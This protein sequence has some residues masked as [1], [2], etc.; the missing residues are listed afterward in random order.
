MTG[1]AVSFFLYCFCFLLGSVPFGLLIA[2]VFSVNNLRIHGSG[3]IGATNVA[4]VVGFWPAGFLTFVLDTSKGIVPA[5]LLSE[6]GVSLLSRFFWAHETVSVGA[7]PFQSWLA[8]LL[9]VLGHCYSPWLRFRGGKGVATGFGVV[10]VLSPASAFFGLLA[11]G[12]VFWLKKIASLASIAGVILIG[13]S[14]FVIHP[15][16]AHHW[17]SSAILLLILI[18]HEKNIDALLENKER[19]F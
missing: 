10:L 1:I 14:D 16:G 2:R 11:F 3:N 18:R 9:A 4:R 7:S 19:V 5:L 17:V 6:G 12:M 15:L 8:G 13:I